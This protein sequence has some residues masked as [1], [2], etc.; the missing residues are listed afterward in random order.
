M[1][2]PQESVD[3]DGERP[4]LTGTPGVVSGTTGIRRHRPELWPLELHRPVHHRGHAA[5]P[6]LQRPH[7]RQNLQDGLT[8]RLSLMGL[9][10]LDDGRVAKAAQTATRLG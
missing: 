10:V 6:A 4:E 9:K 1:L 5:R 7:R 2:Y 3:A 8:E